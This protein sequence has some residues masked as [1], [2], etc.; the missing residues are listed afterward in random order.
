MPDAR[1]AGTP[2]ARVL[3]A[4]G[5]QSPGPSPVLARHEPSFGPSDVR[6]AA[7]DAGCQPMGA[8]ASHELA[9]AGHNLQIAG[10]LK[11]S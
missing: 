9:F 10:A 6:R 11:G 5:G 4:Q 3:S 2:P 8:L 7:I 1:S